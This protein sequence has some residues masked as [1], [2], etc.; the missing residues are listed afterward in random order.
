M[1]SIVSADPTGKDLTLYGL[2]KPVATV[3]IGAGSSRA[4][5][6]IGKPGPTGQVY[7]RDLSRPMVFTIESSIADDLKK[8]TDDYRPKDIFEFRSFTATRLEVTRGA[9]KMAFE[10]VKVKDAADKWQLA[11][12]KKDVDAAKME[13]LL[14]SLTDLSAVSF[15]DARTKT[16]TDTPAAIVV[17]KSD[18]DKKE[19]K[20]VFGKAGSDVFAVRAGD[21]G[22]AR[23][24]A[25][26]FDAAMKALDALK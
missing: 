18:D 21:A 17:A 6:A 26:K 15:A 20:V 19:E 22:A 23:V 25:A 24:D 14:S 1:K 11:G 8:K 5:V 2:D 10:K 13:A 16:G 9:S 7:A 3:V 4:S 12:A